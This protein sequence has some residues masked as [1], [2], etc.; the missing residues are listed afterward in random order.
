M[1]QILKYFLCVFLLGIAANIAADEPAMEQ[2]SLIGPPAISSETLV[3]ALRKDLPPIQELL[4]LTD[5]VVGSF[6][7]AGYAMQKYQFPN[8]KIAGHAEYKDFLFKFAVR[9][10]WPELV[11]ILNKVIASITPPEHDQIFHKWM[12]VRYEQAVVWRTV[13]N[14]VLWVGG[15]LGAISGLMLFWNRKL[16]K[17]I[18]Q[19]SKVEIALRESE[20]RFRV[21]FEQAAVGVAQIDSNTGRFVHI[22][23]KLLQKLNKKCGTF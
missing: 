11:S 2:K 8:L 10:D 1:K 12:P 9:N 13:I 15:V 6:I 22:N 3:I 18:L 14:W 16:A 17:E 19:R 23:Q 7:V 21:L 20:S 5:A 4:F